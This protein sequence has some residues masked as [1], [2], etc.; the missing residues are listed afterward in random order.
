MGVY[1][2]I[3]NSQSGYNYNY[4]NGQQQ[5]NNR[6]YGPSNSNVG[7]SY[8]GLSP[9]PFVQPIPPQPG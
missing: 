3:Q 6:P 8:G 9:W 5:I 2:G 4:N 1:A 7:G